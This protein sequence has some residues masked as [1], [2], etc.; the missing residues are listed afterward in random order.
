MVA[1]VIEGLADD[2]QHG[3]FLPHVLLRELRGPVPRL[4]ASLVVEVGP[5]SHCLAGANE[6]CR[7][8]FSCV[9]NAARHFGSDVPP[10]RSG[11]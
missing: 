3:Q 11:T 1:Q 4:K 7:V 8:G 9:E 6:K 10:Y 2:P 5:A